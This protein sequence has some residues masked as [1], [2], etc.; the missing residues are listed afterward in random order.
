MSHLHVFGCWAFAHVQ[1]DKRKSF[2][3]KSRK[4]I[5]LGY[6]VDYKGWKCWDPE[7]NEVFISHDVCFV[8]TEM[9][10]AEL[11]LPGPHYEPL[12]GVQPGSVGEPADTATPPSSSSSSVPPVEPASTPSD[13]AD[14]DSGSEPDLDNSDFIECLIGRLAGYR[15]GGGEVESMEVAGEGFSPKVSWEMSL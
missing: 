5:F 4:C 13:D 2:Q 3:P 9:P 1:K 8:E 12:S 6:P 11:G 14:S 10:G 15:G 7:R